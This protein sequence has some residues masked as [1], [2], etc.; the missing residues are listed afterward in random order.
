[1]VTTLLC[2]GDSNTFG[3]DPRSYLGERYPRSVR[4]TGLLAEEGYTVRNEGMNGRSIPRDNG[5]LA[6]VPLLL[7]TPFRLLTVQLGINDLLND[8]SLTAEDCARRMETFL[9]ALLSDGAV[10]PR[11]ILLVAPPPCVP[12]AWVRDERLLEQ[13]ARLGHA[14]QAVAARLGTAFVNA[15]TWQIERV[16]DGVHFSPAG[17]RA[18]AAGMRD[19]L[20]GLGVFPDGP[21]A[22]PEEKNSPRRQRQYGFDGGEN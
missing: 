13:S 5:I 16:F 4:W 19:A 6:A 9:S 22:L 1:M 21:V 11:Q 8:P 12:G 15:G 2:Y 3:Y 10:L 18:Y 17:H 7:E 20:A 14:Y